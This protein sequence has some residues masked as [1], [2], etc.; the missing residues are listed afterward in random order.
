MKKRLLLIYQI[1]IIL[2]CS[3]NEDRGYLSKDFLNKELD[4]C[5]EQYKLMAQ[6][7]PDSLFP[8]TFI[9][10]NL[11]TSNSEWWCSGFF[12]GG[13]VY[14][15]E[16]T[17]DR[18]FN[19]QVL[20]RFKYLEKEKLNSRDHDIGFKIYCSFGNMLRV[21]DDLSKYKPIIIE[22]A[23]TLLTRYNPEMGVIR[24]WNNWK[25]EWQYAVI[26]DNMMNLEL[27]LAAT[28][29][30][31]DSTYF[32]VA[33]SH[34]DRT[35]ENHF[36]EDNSSYHVL[37][38]D[39]LSGK[40]HLKQTHQGF[41]DESSWARG[42]AWGLYAYTFMHKLTGYERYLDRAVKIAEFILNH[43]NL[44]H[45]LIPYW[46]YDAKTIPNAPRDASA[47]AITAS[48]L[49][50]LSELTKVNNDKYLKAA[51]TIVR[52]LSSPE[53]KAI[54]GENGNFILK[55]SV[56]SLPNDSEV[57]VPLSY[58]DYYYI[59]TLMKLKRK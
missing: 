5:A 20:N 6:T 25:E 7:C 53:Y 52:T 35:E 45:D 31:G 22:A 41:S 46:D 27:L 47:A 58:A 38:Y 11:V 10:N 21:T 1:L 12:P 56:G 24:S 37:S 59:E 32:N 51:N 36:R 55:K 18:Y 4:F 44:P 40:P 16:Y 14:L 43:P 17:G 15:Y 8:K 26:I 33:I 54:L 13:L 23:N 48:A 30:S 57:D 50:T 39:T 29:L 2:S 49:V 34:A 28:T 42:Q 9:D 19:D 3:P